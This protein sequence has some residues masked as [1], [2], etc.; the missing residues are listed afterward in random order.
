MAPLRNFDPPLRAR[1]PRARRERWQRPICAAAPLEGQT[2]V[3]TQQHVSAHGGG[4]VRL[5]L[6]SLIATFFA[7]MLGV[8]IS[9]LSRSADGAPRRNNDQQDVARYILPPGNYGG[10]PTTDESR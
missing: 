9:A 8:G 7:A 2:A 3:G 4:P 6:R 5:S 1:D 10:L